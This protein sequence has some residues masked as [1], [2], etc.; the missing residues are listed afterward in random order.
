M[1]DVASPWLA[2][3]WRA[4]LCDAIDI[5]EEASYTVATRRE[6]DDNFQFGEA[7]VTKNVSDSFHIQTLQ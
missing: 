1:K 5:Q 2:L 3:P 7:A 6:M 4:L